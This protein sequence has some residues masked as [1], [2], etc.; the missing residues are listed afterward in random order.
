MEFK[1]YSEYCYQNHSIKSVIFQKILF[2]VT[3]RDK[4][5]I[6]WDDR[7]LSKLWVVR[8]MYSKTNQRDQIFI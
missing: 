6:N 2:I 5:K 4:E 8:D 3:M 7:N 1:E